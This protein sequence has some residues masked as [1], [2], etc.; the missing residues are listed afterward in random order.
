MQ[1]ED[2]TRGL[3]PGSESGIADY[4]I[5]RFDKM[6][7]NRSTW[8]AHWQ[9]IAELVLPRRADFVSKQTRGL[10]R[11]EKIYDGT[12]P[13]AAEQ[14]AAGL[15]S[16]L[17]SPE[18]PWFALTLKNKMMLN[19]KGVRD[20]L[21]ETQRAMYDV[22]NSPEMNFHPQ[23]HE[24][25]LD[26]SAFGTSV[27]Y[28]D[29]EVGK[30]I[31]FSTLHLADCFI[32]EDHQGKIDTLDRRIKMSYRQIIQ[33]WGLKSLNAKMTRDAEQDQDKE[34]DLIHCVMPRSDYSGRTKKKDQKSK[35]WGSYYIHID[36]RHVVHESGYD[37]FPFLV[38]RWS[39]LVGETYGRSPAMTVLPDV[40]MLNEMSKTVIKAAQKAVDPPLMVPDDG[41]MNPVRTVPGGLNYYR[42]GTQDRIEP[43]KNHQNFTVGLDMM[44]QRREHITKAFYVDMLL[45]PQQSK[46]HMEQTATEILQ[47]REEKMRLMSPM[48]GRMQSEFLGPLIKRVYALLE[49]SNR[50]PVLPLMGDL[51]ALE[52]EY[53]SPIA[54]AQKAIESESLIRTLEIMSPFI[55]ADPSLMSNID[56]DKAFR[57]VAKLFAIPSNIMKD[58]QTVEQER[59]AQQQ[60]VQ[61]QQM[62]ESAQGAADAYQKFGKGESDFA[63]GA[64]GGQEQAL[65]I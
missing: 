51:G 4:I 30:G 42:S 29:E 61:A 13:W 50:L 59:M 25:Y 39:K 5:R 62:I 23:A 58:E 47:R 20:W 26:V 34:V 1:T 44:Q 14:L 24:L 46:T 63:Q 22:F 2:A 36:T 53:V 52:I 55:E 27:M 18:Q 37:E 33:R 8:E 11:T 35:S 9:E 17:T 57:W 60:Q 31:R 21:L 40:K 43:L 19:N 45:T 64:L 3:T 32:M 38:P 16:F 65:P 10:K 49:R 15:Q 12:A 56:G 6:R 54:R 7:G 41:F 48:M 28:I